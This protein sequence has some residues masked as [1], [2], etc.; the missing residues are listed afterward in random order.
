MAQRTKVGKAVVIY[1]QPGQ[2]YSRELWDRLKL[3]EAMDD[4]ELAKTLNNK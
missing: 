4:D 2:A 1:N 3:Q